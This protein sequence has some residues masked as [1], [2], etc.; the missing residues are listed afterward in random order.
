MSRPLTL[1]PALI[2]A[3]QTVADLEALKPHVK[4]ESQLLFDNKWRL[5]SN[6]KS[7]QARAAK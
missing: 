6:S 2:E 7:E 3:A 1:D 4:P 5:L